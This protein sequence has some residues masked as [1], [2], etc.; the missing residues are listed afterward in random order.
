MRRFGRPVDMSRLRRLALTCVSLAA[1]VALVA[2][3]SPRIGGIEGRGTRVA[4][5]LGAEVAKEGLPLGCEAKVALDAD[6]SDE[7]T[8]QL[9]ALKR[10]REERED[11]QALD[12]GFDRTGGGVLAEVVERVESREGAR[13]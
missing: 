11:R 2:V 12:R 5:Q 7:Q 4:A 10:C 3:V 13:R 1:F 8:E 6:A 9:A